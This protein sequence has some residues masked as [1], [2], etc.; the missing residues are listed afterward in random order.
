MVAQ[1]AP[2]DLI[3]FEEDADIVVLMR[4]VAQRTGNC[5][6]IGRL[7]LLGTCPERQHRW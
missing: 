6:D 1:L 5:P 3:Y 7:G 4:Q 2:C